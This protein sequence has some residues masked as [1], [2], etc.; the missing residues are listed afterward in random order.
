MRSCGVPNLGSIPNVASRSRIRRSHAG[1]VC[2]IFFGLF[3]TATISGAKSPQKADVWGQ[4][5]LN[6]HRSPRCLPPPAAIQLFHRAG[7]SVQYYEISAH[8]LAD[9]P[10]GMRT[11]GP[12]DDDGIRRDA[13]LSWHIWW[14]WEPRMRP[15][16]DTVRVRS[17]SHLILPRWC[18][19]SEPA[20]EERHEWARYLTTVL[21]H[22]AGHA[23][24]FFDHL[25]SFRLRLREFFSRCETCSAA[26]GNR[27]GINLVDKLNVVQREYDEKT[28]HGA[29]QHAR[30]QRAFLFPHRRRPDKVINSSVSNLTTTRSP[31]ARG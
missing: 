29:T 20:E 26:D 17:S 8:T 18:P 6:A 7:I 10:A 24:I 11:T 2:S 1:L 21:E 13:L 19:A 25:K 30:V 22:E 31:A 15:R 12:L 4:R 3:L 28:G 27:F 5:H 16:G 14:R 23:L 9:V